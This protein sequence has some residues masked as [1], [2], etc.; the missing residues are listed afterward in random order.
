MEK[1]YLRPSG[2][3]V[4]A[5]VNVSLVPGPE[6]QPGHLI[7]GD[8]G[9]HRAKAIRDLVRESEERLPSPRAGLQ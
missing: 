8:P 1:R 9:Y 3:I 4:W 7:A 2:K 5:L 6:G